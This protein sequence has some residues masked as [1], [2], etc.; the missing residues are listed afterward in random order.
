MKNDLNILLAENSDGLTINPSTLTAV[1]KNNGYFVSITDNEYKRV[2][3][4]TVNSLKKQAKKL[5][6]KKFYIGYWKDKKTNL[7]F[8]DLSLFIKDK[9]TALNLAKTFNQKAIF[10]AKKKDCIYV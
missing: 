2:G 6:L 7:K 9:K 5:N 3:I 10:D 1:N 8:V 4:K